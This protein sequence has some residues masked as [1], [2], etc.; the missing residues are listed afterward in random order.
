MTQRSFHPPAAPPNWRGGLALVG[1]LVALLIFA[2][3]EHARLPQTVTPQRWQGVL[4]L[5]TLLPLLFISCAAVT[6]GRDMPPGMPFGVLCTTLALMSWIASGASPLVFGH[7]VTPEW[8]ETLLIGVVT[9]GILWQALLGMREGHRSFLATR[10]AA[11]RDPLTGLLGREGLR[12]RVGELPPGDAL[13]VMADLNLLRLVN[14]SR[15]HGAGDA[16]I[17]AVASALRGAFPDSALWCRWGGDEFVAVLPGVSEEAARTMMTRAAGLVPPPTPNMPPLAFGVA[18]GTVGEAFERSLA[19]ADQRMYEAKQAQHLRLGDGRDTLAL[20]ELSR[21]IEALATP[22]EVIRVGLPLVMDLLGF[23]GIGFIERREGGWCLAHAHLREGVAFDV[24][25]PG[26]PLPEEGLIGRAA[27]EERGVW[28]T[29][30]EEEPDAVPFWVDSGIRSGG[31]VP[32]RCDG[33]AVGML[34]LL[35]VGTWRAVTPQVCRVME[36]AALRLGHALELRQAVAKVQATLEHGLLALGVALEARDLETHG[37]TERVVRLALRLGR[38]LGLSCPD[39]EALRQGACLHDLGK[40][41]IPD[42]ILRKPGGLDA[43]EWAVMQTHAAVGAGIAARIPNLEPGVL[44]VIRHHHERWDGAG[45]PGGLAGE[46]IPL[47]ARVFAVCD[48]YDALTSERP[49]K[50][51]WTPGRARAELQAQAGRQFD[52]GVVTA[53]LR[54]LRGEAEVAV[55]RS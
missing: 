5:L 51:A 19:L 41:A 15:G 13:V 32:V 25:A 1:V 12:R 43:D 49:Y 20:D 40:L 7:R 55:V 10:D 52:P 8:F 44:E 6:F 22:D 37:H 27:R 23:D 39:L 45:Y 28:S 34:I 50:E 53:F 4:R 29:A 18:R 21:R 38:A 42:R 46:A 33:R 17:R 11:E 31:V 35:K 9:F 47:L 3:Y 2:L 24:P 36:T 30:Y 26:L 48:V 14:D 16:Q 54:V